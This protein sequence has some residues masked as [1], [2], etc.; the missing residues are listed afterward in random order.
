MHQY[1]TRTEEVHLVIL[2]AINTLF[3]RSLSKAFTAPTS[4]PTADAAAT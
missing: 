4:A 2:L 1:I 3:Y